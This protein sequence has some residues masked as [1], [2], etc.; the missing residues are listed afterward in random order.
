M[1]KAPAVKYYAQKHKLRKEAVSYA[2]TIEI[3]AEIKLGE[4]LKEMDKNKGSNPGLQPIDH[5]RIRCT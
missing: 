2:N 4:I 1:D 5:G 3:S